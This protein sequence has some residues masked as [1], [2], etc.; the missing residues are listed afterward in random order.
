MPSL[1]FWTERDPTVW[2]I[3]VVQVENASGGKITRTNL[4]DVLGTI[5]AGI[6][7][8]LKE[9]EIAHA[10]HDSGD[11]DIGDASCERLMRRASKKIRIS[12]WSSSRPA[13]RLA[14]I[15]RAPK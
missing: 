7:R 13:Y 9:G 1:Q 14:G 10:M 15:A 4:S 11:F 6:G 2:P 12:V 8:S 5:E 3:L